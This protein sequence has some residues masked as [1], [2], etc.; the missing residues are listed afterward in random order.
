MT[1]FGLHIIL[2]CF[3]SFSAYSQN[4][5]YTTSTG[6]TSFISDAVLENIEASN[7][8][9]A[10]ILNTSNKQIIVKI[11]IE[12]FQFRNQLMQEH[13]N[14]IF[15]ESRKYPN[16]MFKGKINES[17]NLNKPGTYSISATGLLS[18][19]GVVRKRTLHG[20]LVVSPQ[21]YKLDTQFKVL[22]EDHKILIPELVFN[23]VAESILITTQLY[24]L[25]ILDN[26]I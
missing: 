22:L 16:A 12:R 7:K 14:E 3:Y 9:V 20:K 1:K 8:N 5:I 11:L 6:Q 10:S 24:L 21:G 26:P 13:F 25:P 17:F 2:V 23:K 19:H 4:T 18:I 15:M